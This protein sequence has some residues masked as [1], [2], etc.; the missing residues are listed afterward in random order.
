MKYLKLFAAVVLL[1]I[2]IGKIGYEY[3]YAGRLSSISGL[4]FL[5]F[6]VL[7]YFLICLSYMWYDPFGLKIFSFVYIFIM[8]AFLTVCMSILGVDEDELSFVI[9]YMILLGTAFIAETATLIMGIRQKI[10]EKANTMK[11]E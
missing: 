8:F 1:E 4:Y 5:A 3:G 7:I 11:V 10:A 6:Y 2:M 9:I